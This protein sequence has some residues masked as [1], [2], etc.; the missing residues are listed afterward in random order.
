MNNKIAVITGATSG[1]GYVTAIELAKK[2]FDLILVARN[3]AKVSA[4]QKVIGDHVKTDFVLCDLS[5]IF[6]RGQGKQ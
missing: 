4:L 2:G 1:I 3:E 5:S 6:S